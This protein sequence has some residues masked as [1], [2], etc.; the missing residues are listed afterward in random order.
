MAR[1]LIGAVALAALTIAGCGGSASTTT[2][3]PSTTQAPSTTNT[4]VVSGPVV[5]GSGTMP[6]TVPA[7]FP[8]P[9]GGAIG[10]T[11]QDTRNGRT[12]V[13]LVVPGDPRDI[14]AYYEENL[15]AAGFEITETG[16]QGAA[17]VISFTGHGV[18]GE[19]VVAVGSMTTTTVAVTL[20]PS[21]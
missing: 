13:V 4:T 8:V 11:L 1:I 16:E 3:S 18:D 2:T 5:F 9:E 19:V 15:P 17:Q 14:V 6:D 21:A 10:D 7:E 20:V 12:E